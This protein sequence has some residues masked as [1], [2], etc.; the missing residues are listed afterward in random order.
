MTL[1]PSHK[2]RHS[3][4]RETESI[5]PSKVLTTL[6][7][8]LIKADSLVTLCDTN[9]SGSRLDLYSVN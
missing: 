5:S 3:R 8:T 1:R 6:V 9:L 2:S 4:F 7:N